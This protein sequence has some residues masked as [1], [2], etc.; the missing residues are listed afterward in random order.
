M[1][2]TPARKMVSRRRRQQR[3]FSLIELGIVIAVIAV[4]AS[5][6]IFGRGFIAAARITKAVE[7]MNTIRKS[8]SSYA[9]LQ[10]GSLATSAASQLPALA[11]RQLLPPL[12]TATGTLDPVNGSWFVSGSGTDSI[13]INSIGFANVPTPAG[14][15]NAVSI[16]VLAPTAAMARTCGIRSRPIGT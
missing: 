12:T 6:V 11:N 5:V 4:L 15:T 2:A 9:G 10:G 8:A 13:S 3:G 16:R 1:N 7:A 14:P